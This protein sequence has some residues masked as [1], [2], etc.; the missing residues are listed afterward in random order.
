[1]HNPPLDGADIQ[2]ETSK[3]QDSGED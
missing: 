2:V 3:E 1:V